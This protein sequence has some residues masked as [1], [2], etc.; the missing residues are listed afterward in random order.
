[1]GQVSRATSKQHTSVAG[2]RLQLV[3]PVVFYTGLRPWAGLR[4]LT[5]VMER[6]ERFR[7]RT[8][9]LEPLFIN[10]GAIPSEQLEGEGGFFGWVLRLIQQRRAPLEEFRS[11][12]RRAFVRHPFGDARGALRRAWCAAIL[13][14]D[15]SPFTPAPSPEQRVRYDVHRRDA[16]AGPQQ[17]R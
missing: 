15:G 16:L 12:L 3:L 1:M 13:S 8:P 14:Q 6:G 17:G 11:L 10:L 4:T 7:R 5:D 9:Q 2:F